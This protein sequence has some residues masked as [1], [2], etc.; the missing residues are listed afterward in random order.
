M[1][2]ASLEA[3]DWYSGGGRAEFLAAYS[4]TG[5]FVVEGIFFG[6]LEGTFIFFTWFVSIKFFSRREF[7]V[8]G[9]LAQRTALERPRTAKVSK[10]EFGC[11]NTLRERQDI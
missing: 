11:A 7:E 2:W 8:N 1:D 3:Y 4:A 10:N 9:L 5:G 6:T